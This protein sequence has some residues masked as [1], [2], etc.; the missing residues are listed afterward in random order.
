MYAALDLDTGTVIG[1]LHQRHR[2]I[3]FKRFLTTID[4]NV[5]AGFDVHVV[6]DNASSHDIRAWI[7]TWNDSGH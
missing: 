4:R 2:A 7:N 3:E 5:P 6:L 1:S